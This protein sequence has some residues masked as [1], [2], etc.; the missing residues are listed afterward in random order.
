MGDSTTAREALAR[1]I[2]ARIC[3][4]RRSHDQIKHIDALLCDIERAEDLELDTV[5]NSDPIERPSH[6][7]RG[8]FEVIDI[9]EDLRFGW[10]LGNVF[11][12][13]ARAGHKDPAKELEDLRKAR[14]YLNRYIEF[15]AVKDEAR[16]DRIAR[17]KSADLGLNKTGAD[18]TDC[19]APV[20]ELHAD[21]CQW[22][23]VVR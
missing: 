4:E 3:D 11:K 10:H 9:I 23:E 6:Y 16:R 18:C 13:V 12:Y 17:F 19:A 7:T 2:C 8:K 15:K 1:S 22:V 14:W 20:D 5:R 21:G